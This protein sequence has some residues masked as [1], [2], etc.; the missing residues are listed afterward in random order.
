MRLLSTRHIF[1]STAARDDGT[2]YSPSFRVPPN[3]IQCSENQ[4]IR[5]T[6]IRWSCF[7]GW[8]NVHD[9]DPA[10]NNYFTFKNLNTNV[11]TT[12]TLPPGNYPYSK[13]AKYINTAYPD[14]ACTYLSTTNKLQFQFTVPHALQ[15]EG[16]SYA[17]LGFTP[18]DAALEDGVE[19][20]ANNTITSTGILKGR[21][22]DR[23]LISAT[24]LNARQDGN[25]EN[26]TNGKLQM[27]PLLAAVTITA[28][29]YTYQ[30]YINTTGEEMSLYITDR[31]IQT[32]SFEFRD[33]NTGELATFM[34]G[35]DSDLVLKIDIFQV[36]DVDHQN[37]TLSEIKH[38]LK[39]QLLSQHLNKLDTVQNFVGDS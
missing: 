26:I 33:G 30:N 29:P 11:Y 25:Y 5:I 3:V 32:L 6:V 34:E 39:L 12:V 20:D 14:C 28:A 19:T 7:I 24:S 17:I 9:S 18:Q 10:P 2:S 38:Y 27:S 15:L 21:A 31:T 4:I 35:Y 13:I 1:L 37:I 22:T 36:D 16:A 23:I 8:P